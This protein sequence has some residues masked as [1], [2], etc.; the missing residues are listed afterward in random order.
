MNGQVYL[1]SASREFADTEVQP[2][3]RYLGRSLR[4]AGVLKLIACGCG[5]RGLV[6]IRR[7]AWMRVFPAFRQYRCLACG[8][9]IFRPRLRDRLG[10]GALYVEPAPLPPS[11]AARSFRSV[12]MAAS[13]IASRRLP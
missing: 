11:S 3:G 8:A 2:A 4:A 7:A 10:Y 12:S 13:S 5:S 9:R 1:H 6:R